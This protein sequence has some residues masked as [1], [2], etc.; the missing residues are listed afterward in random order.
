M[1]ERRAQF[2]DEGWVGFSSRRI[3]IAANSQTNVTVIRAVPQEQKWP[4]RDWGIWL[5]V[6]PQSSDPLAAKLCVRLL[7]CASGTRFNAGLVA[8]IALAVVLLSYGGYYY[9]K[10]RARPG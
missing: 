6:T 7:V 4:S 9:F 1:R 3:E 8:R 5:G 2:P 10:R